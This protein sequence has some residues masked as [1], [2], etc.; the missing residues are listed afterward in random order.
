MKAELDR[1][2]QETVQTYMT[3]A[4]DV[5]RKEKMV[6][7]QIEDVKRLVTESKSVLLKVQKGNVTA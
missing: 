2:E 5:R 3:K 4:G 6:S 7:E 1:R